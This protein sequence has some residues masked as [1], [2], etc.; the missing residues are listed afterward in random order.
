MLEDQGAL[1]GEFTTQ[2][3]SL[4]TAEPGS[5]AR[6]EQWETFGFA[7]VST[8]SKSLLLIE[9][10]DGKGKE[11]CNRGEGCCLGVSGLSGLKV[12]PIG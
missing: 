11:G 12:A 5:R 10:V 8:R 2:A 9:C 7:T 4:S 3:E 1:K 6:A